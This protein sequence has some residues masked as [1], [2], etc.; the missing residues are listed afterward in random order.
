MEYLTSLQWWVRY[1][2]FSDDLHYLS[3]FLSVQF[4]TFEHFAGVNYLAEYYRPRV[5][6]L[7]V[8]NNCSIMILNKKPPNENDVTSIQMKIHSNETKNKDF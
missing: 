2:G 8:F 4:R 7:Q 6:V 3:C 1:T 5:D